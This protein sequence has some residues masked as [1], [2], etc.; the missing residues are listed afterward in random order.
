MSKLY[1]E[2]F[3]LYI[4]DINRLIVEVYAKTDTILNDNI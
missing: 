1:N 3:K 2:K 4:N